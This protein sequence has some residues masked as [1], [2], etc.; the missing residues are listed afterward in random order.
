VAE[1]WSDD[2]AALAERSRHDLRSLAAT[3]TALSTPKETKMRFFKTHPALGALVALL[4]LSLVGGA[5]YAVVREVFITIDHDKPA[6]QIEKDVHDQLEAAGVPATVHA[7]KRDDGKTEIRI[8]MTGSDHDVDLKFADK[9][10]P[11]E[12]DS[13]RLQLEVQIKCQLDPAQTEAVTAIASGEQ[14]IDL[15]IN[16]GDKT[17]DEII[18]AVKAAYADGGFKD[19]DVT[20]TD[21]DK[22]MVTVKSPPVAK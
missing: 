4:F 18:A 22:L 7:A 21:G 12:Q 13:D 2:F 17:D 9:N 14:V 11:V 1:P 3:R 8:G 19:V 10:G 15:A 5:A 20:I 16:R 6:D